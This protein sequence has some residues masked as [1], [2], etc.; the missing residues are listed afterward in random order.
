MESILAANSLLD[1]LFPTPFC[2]IIASPFIVVVIVSCTVPECTT[3]SLPEW[4]T[5][6]PVLALR[7]PDPVHLHL[8]TPKIC[9]LY[10]FVSH[11]GC[12]LQELSCFIHR[13]NLPKTYIC[14]MFAMEHFHFHRFQYWH[15]SWY[16]TLGSPS[17]PV[18]DTSVA[19]S[20]T[21]F[22]PGMGGQPCT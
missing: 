17:C 19:D 14:F 5:V 4:A 15:S 22:F 9:K 18:F 20:E 16:D 10:I 8:L 1:R 7:C 3:S 21:N 6:S 11:F 12:C 2:R 13:V